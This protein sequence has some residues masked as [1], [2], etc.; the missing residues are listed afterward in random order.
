MFTET[1]ISHFADVFFLS[2]D[3]Y[4]GTKLKVQRVFY[5]R[6]TALALRSIALCAS[7]IMAKDSLSHDTNWLF[8]AVTKNKR[9]TL[10]FWKFPN[11]PQV[12]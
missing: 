5:T 11:F 3:V 10:V 6:H 4:A 12:C 1:F 9:K 2:L 7:E 8:V